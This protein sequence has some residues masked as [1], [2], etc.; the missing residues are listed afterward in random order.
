MS[1]NVIQQCWE[2]Q[3]HVVDLAIADHILDKIE[4][5]HGVALEEVEDACFN[6]AAHYR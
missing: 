4:Q 3:V 5:K 6:R 1:Y 2:L